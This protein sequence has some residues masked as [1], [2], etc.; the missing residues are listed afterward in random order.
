MEPGVSEMRTGVP[1]ASSTAFHGSVSSTCSVPSFA[2]RNPTVRP[3][4]APAVSGMIVVLQRGG[5]WDGSAWGRTIVRPRNPAGLPARPG[6]KR[7][8]DAAHRS[9]PGDEGSVAG[10][11][12]RAVATA[13]RVGLDAMGDDV[14]AVTHPAA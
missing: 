1:P 8:G 2:H 6:A 12:P 9:G 10:A 4:S 11:G 3:A 7:G 14:D 5:G 13:P